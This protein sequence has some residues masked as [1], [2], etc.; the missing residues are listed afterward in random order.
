MHDPKQTYEEH[1]N[2]GELWLQYCTDCQQFIFYPR[3]HCPGCWGQQW[4]WRR[5]RGQGQ[6]YSYSVVHK[7]TLTESGGDIPYIYA[8]VTLH[9]GVVMATRIVDCDPEAVHID[10]AVEM[11]IDEI[12]RKACLVFR[13]LNSTPTARP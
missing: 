13:P 12:S 5:T 8:L 4:E 1:I 3:S 9:E 6:V 11:T 10:M 7:S 2:K